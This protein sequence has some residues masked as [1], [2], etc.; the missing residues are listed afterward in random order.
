MVMQKRH[1]YMTKKRGRKR[2]TVRILITP[3][4][5]DLLRM[6]ARKMDTYDDHIRNVLKKAG[7]KV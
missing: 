2:K 7:Y 6:T 4:T 1:K 5:R 3:K